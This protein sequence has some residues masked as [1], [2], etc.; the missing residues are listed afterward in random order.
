MQIPLLKSSS[1]LIVGLIGLGQTRAVLLQSKYR[2]DNGY[3]DDRKDEA[4][5]G[6]GSIVEK[7]DDINIAAQHSDI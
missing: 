5:D 4:D 6:H 1:D 7:T 3:N 2:S